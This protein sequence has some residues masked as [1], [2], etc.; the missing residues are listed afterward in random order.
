[1]KSSLRG[2]PGPGIPGDGCAT[3]SQLSWMALCCSVCASLSSEWS[4][5]V[6]ANPGPRVF[7]NGEDG[8]C[9]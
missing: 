7:G 9:V 5:R 4:E 3:I 6:G 1:M 8:L 2:G